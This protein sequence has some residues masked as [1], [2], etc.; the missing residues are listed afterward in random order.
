MKGRDLERNTRND[1]RIDRQK[2][3]SALSWHRDLNRGFS[4]EQCPFRPAK[5]HSRNSHIGE[6]KN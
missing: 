1:S 5:V 3:H 6:G 4:R 2:Y